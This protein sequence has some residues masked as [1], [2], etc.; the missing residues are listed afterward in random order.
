MAEAA[1]GRLRRRELVSAAF[2]LSFGLMFGFGIPFSLTSAMLLVH[3]LWLGTDLIGAWFPGPSG[4]ELGLQWR[5]RLGL[6][7][8]ILAGALYGATLFLGLEGLGWLFE[9]LPVKVSDSFG[10][11]NGPIVLTFAAFPAVAV[12]YQ[13]GV[14]RGII[15]FLITLV[16]WLSASA[17]GFDNPN[18]WALVAGMGVLIVHAV[19]ERK[20]KGSGPGLAALTT[21]RVSQ[22]R[23]YLPVIAL[24]G[25]VYGLACNQ[26]I[27]MEGP[28]SSAALAQGERAAAVG[29]TAA[30]A[31]SFTPLKAMSA[32]VTGVFVMDGFG[33]VAMVG[34]ASPSAVVA[35]VSGA[36]VMSIEALSLTFVVRFL[37]RFPGLLKS[38]DS[39]R[40]AMTKLLEV[41]ALVGGMVAANSIAPGLGFVAV[42]GLYLLNE[43]AGTPVVRAAVGPVGV[44][45]VGIVVNLL[46]LLRLV[47]PA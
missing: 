29:F 27:L 26:A 33:F 34:V 3:G 32:L 13:H 42:A 21:E 30:R 5:G 2:G 41:G 18:N 10:L 43:S 1:E 44:I 11:L 31:L 45:L 39:A 23:G 46:V 20:P 37:D 25:A 17:L 28:Q 22:I 12:G 40:W 7:A 38:A 47:P 19:W 4:K 35:A 8:A 9:R 36:I 14:R 16:A 24:L 6:V 15:A